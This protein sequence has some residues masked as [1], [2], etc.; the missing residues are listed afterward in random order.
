[1]FD[2]SRDVMVSQVAAAPSDLDVGVAMELEMPESTISQLQ[3][4]LQKMLSSAPFADKGLF[5][6]NFVTFTAPVPTIV[7]NISSLFGKNGAVSNA[8]RV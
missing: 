5:K 1:M 7:L 6:P 3:Q 8:I 2:I 4:G